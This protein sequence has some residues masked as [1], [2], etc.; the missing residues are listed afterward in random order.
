MQGLFAP[1]IQWHEQSQIMRLPLAVVLRIFV[2]RE[3]ADRARAAHSLTWSLRLPAV[4]VMGVAFVFA[5]LMSP[6][7]SY[8]RAFLIAANAMRPQTEFA[9]TRS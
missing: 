8:L 4:A 6:F 3:A 1:V 2:G 5:H 7:G 9:G